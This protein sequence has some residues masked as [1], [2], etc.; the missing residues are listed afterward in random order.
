M[1][2]VA[3]EIGV[4]CRRRTAVAHDIDR[5]MAILGRQFMG[6]HI[7]GTAVLLCLP[8]EAQGIIAHRFMS[9]HAAHNGIGKFVVVINGLA[10]LAEAAFQYDPQQGVARS[11]IGCQPCDRRTHAKLKGHPAPSSY[12]KPKELGGRWA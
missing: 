12:I 6:L 1:Q 10:G 5:R 8:D 2:D 7:Q 11:G 3:Q 4:G 9:H